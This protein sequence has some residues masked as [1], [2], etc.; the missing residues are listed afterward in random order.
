MLISY[1][2]KIKG[3][4]IKFK[5]FSAAVTAKFNSMTLQ[6]MFKVELEKEDLLAVYANA[7]SEGTDDL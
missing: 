2:N 1:T 6:E 3:K 5:D 7:F 4:T